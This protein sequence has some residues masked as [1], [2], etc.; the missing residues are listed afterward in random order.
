MPARRESSSQGRIPFPG[1]DPPPSPP[2]PLT[3]QPDLVGTVCQREILRQFPSVGFS[4][5]RQELRKKM[6]ALGHAL[7]T[8]DRSIGRLVSH[9]TLRSD[10]GSLILTDRDPPKPVNL[11]YSRPGK[12]SNRFGQQ[13][14]E[15]VVEMVRDLLA[16]RLDQCWERPNGLLRKVLVAVEWA[17]RIARAVAAGDAQG[18]RAAIREY[19]EHW[20]R[21]DLTADDLLE[22]VQV[23]LFPETFA[24]DPE[25]RREIESWMVEAQRRRDDWLARAVEEPPAEDDAPPLP[26]PRYRDGLIPPNGPPRCGRARL[27]VW[28][29]ALRA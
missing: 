4:I 15:D 12:Q 26:G 27:R 18:T 5:L 3:G 11:A 22:A 19:Q 6:A 13:S 20:G 21:R 17:G 2:A 29:D 25:V 8:V 14:E 10:C 23:G 24:E 9:G 16:H 1:G 28:L 7:S